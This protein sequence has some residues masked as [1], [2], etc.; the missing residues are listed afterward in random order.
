MGL[1]SAL[2]LAAKLVLQG[3]QD[4]LLLVRKHAG[5]GCN[6]P[7]QVADNNGRRLACWGTNVTEIAGVQKGQ[8]EYK[9]AT[10][11]MLQH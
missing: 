5:E 2:S 11:R 4:L 1:S 8:C 3:H 7:S 9:H 10:V 6:T